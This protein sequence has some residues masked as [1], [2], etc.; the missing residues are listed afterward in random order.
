MMLDAASKPRKR[1][2]GSCRVRQDWNLA[3]GLGGTDA[4]A[5]VSYS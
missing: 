3:A 4:R 1:D 2:T 5:F